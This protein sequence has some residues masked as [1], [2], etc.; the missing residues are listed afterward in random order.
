MK[1]IKYLLV[2]VFI[3]GGLPV[4]QSG[5]LRA[6]SSSEQTKK[7]RRK[8]KKKS[9][10]KKSSSSKKESSSKSKKKKRRKKKKKPEEEAKSE[11]TES[12][13]V[14]NGSSNPT[15]KKDRFNTAAYA[16]ELFNLTGELQA[17]NKELARATRYFY[18][19]EPEKQTVAIESKPFFT[20]EDFEKESRMN[21]DN[22]YVQRQLGMHYQANGDHSSAKEIYLREVSKNPYNPDAHFFLGSLYADL[23]EYQK[24]KYAF[25]EALYLDPNHEAT[26]DAMS[27]F[28]TTEEQKQ[29]SRDVLGYSS[30]KAPDGPAQQINTIREI[31]ASGDFTE[32][33][34]RAQEASEKYPTQ[35]GFIHLIGE[36]HLKLGRTE[37]AKRSFQRAIKL[38]PKDLQPHVALADLYFE[39]GRYVYAALSYSDAVYLDSDNADY[40]Y[41]QGLSY[42]NAYEWGRTAASWEDLLHYRPN[43]P[44]VKTLLPQTYYVLAVE[45]NRI[46]NPTMGR[47][48]FKN[49]L[50]VNNNTTV[51]LPGAMGVLGKFYR[52]KNMYNESLVAFQEALELIPNDAGAYM[53]MGI[54]YWE[55]G[56]KQLARASWE[57]SLEIK[58]ENNESKGWL[59]LSSQGS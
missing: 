19:N 35:S 10:S 21:P 32:A 53:G 47:Q 12:S 26:I 43:D 20:T 30:K 24:A 6:E 57:R 33:L 31:M 3:L 36:N 54:T 59:I 48:A 9:S 27:M 15:A 1:F 37:E 34:N 29:L 22:L 38:N 45:Y 14:D 25:E 50:S 23:G 55:M 5:D 44:I 56:E 2:L 42:F 28:V 18:D 13:K 8:K 39:Q 40:R 16:D 52:G 17:S 46:G 49:A 41:M 11:K 51:W 4:S 7:K 58:P